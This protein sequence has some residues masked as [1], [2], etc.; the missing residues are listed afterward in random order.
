[1]CWDFENLLML[2]KYKGELLLLGVL[3]LLSFPAELELIEDKSVKRKVFS[4]VE[5]ITSNLTQS[6]AIFEGSLNQLVVTSVL[7]FIDR[8][9]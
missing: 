7:F 3:L 2:R 5:P 4:Y 9:G 1:M 8:K 6:N